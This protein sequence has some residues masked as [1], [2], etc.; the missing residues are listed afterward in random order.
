M[1]IV[2]IAANYR[3]CKPV[4]NNLS[5]NERTRSRAMCST[6]YTLMVGWLWPESMNKTWKKVQVNTAI[7]SNKVFAIRLIESFFGHWKL[8]EIQANPCCCILNGWH[9]AIAIF[10][11]PANPITYRS[12]SIEMILSEM[13][14]GQIA[15]T[16]CINNKFVGVKITIDWTVGDFSIACAYL[17]QMLLPLGIANYCGAF[18]TSAC[19]GQMSKNIC[20]FMELWSAFCWNKFLNQCF[21]Y[22]YGTRVQCPRMNWTQTKMGRSFLQSWCQNVQS[23]RANETEKNAICLMSGGHS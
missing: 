9:M 8:Q 17:S 15:P 18:H 12:I 20:T 19:I 2:S 5:M 11:W 16:P 7:L 14:S 13:I 1:H 4:G 23:K 10:S 22:W 21:L 6:H 3:S